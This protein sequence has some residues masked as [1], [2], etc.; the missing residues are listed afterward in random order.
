[1]NNRMRR[2]YQEHQA[3]QPR[4]IAITQTAINTESLILGTAIVS[5]LLAIV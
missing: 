4:A 3:K 1:M 5:L 2:H